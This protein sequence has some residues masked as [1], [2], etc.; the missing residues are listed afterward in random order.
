MG[1]CELYRISIRIIFSLKIQFALGFLTQRWPFFDHLLGMTFTEYKYSLDEGTLTKQLDNCIT[2][3]NTKLFRNDQSINLIDPNTRLEEK[4]SLLYSKTDIDCKLIKEAMGNQIT[5]VE[6][7]FNTSHQRLQD[8]LAEMSR[9]SLN[10]FD[11]SKDDS[12]EKLSRVEKTLLSSQLLIRRDITDL[13]HSL[14]RKITSLKQSLVQ[15]IRNLEVIVLDFQLNCKESF[16]LMEEKSDR[17]KDLVIAVDEKQTNEFGVMR[18]HFELTDSRLKLFQVELGRIVVLME[19]L[20]DKQD[21]TDH[22]FNLMD[23][24]FNEKITAAKLDLVVSKLE[25]LAERQFSL[26]NSLANR[27]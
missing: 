25:D 6:R 26:E 17:I 12:A 18:N 5:D 9:K 20:K 8:C 21:V 23:M 4:L 10:N 2:Y 24:S 19:S 22:R 11:S 27:N 13:K 7:K 1:F 15:V 16:N 14:E 3:I